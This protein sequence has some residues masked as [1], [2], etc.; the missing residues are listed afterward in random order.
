MRAG[1]DPHSVELV[2]VTKTIDIGRMKE[3]FDAGLR[4]FGESR[5]QEARE[6]RNALIG[7]NTQW[8]MIGH[9]QKNK[10]KAAVEIFDLIHSIDSME[11]LSAVDRYAKEQGK[12]Q[13]VLIEVKLSPEE[14]KHGVSEAE[15]PEIIQTASK[16]NHARIEG[17]MTMAPFFENPQNSRLYFRR[18]SE[19]ARIYGLK[20]LSMGMSNDFEV[21]I[22]EGATLVRV[23]TAI[24]G[25]RG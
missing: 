7:T 5:V 6:K 19:I 15:L 24:F 20:E 10:A 22:E 16:M 14:T 1:R 23:G 12:V 21:A 17:L 8:H 2:A 11:L 18:L 13:R 9:L 3:A 25:G 4:V